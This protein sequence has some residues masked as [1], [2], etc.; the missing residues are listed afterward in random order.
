M[1]SLESLRKARKP[2]A[3]FIDMANLKYVHQNSRNVREALPHP[4]VA[5]L[6][7]NWQCLVRTQMWRK[8]GELDIA[9]TQNQE[10]SASYAAE[11]R[12]WWQPTGAL[13]KI[14]QQT[15]LDCFDCGSGCHAGVTWG[16]VDNRKAASNRADLSR[17]SGH[18]AIFAKPESLKCLG[19]RSFQPR[20]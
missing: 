9:H 1:V 7:R 18:L 8:V 20:R 10:A 3:A 4:F 12:H 17:V 14:A 2:K 15:L 13:Q 11:I 6:K 16:P 19:F 5:S